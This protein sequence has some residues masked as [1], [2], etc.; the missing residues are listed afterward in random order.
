MRCSKE[1]PCSNCI[2]RDIVED[3]RREVVVLTKHQKNQP[4]SNR[5]SITPA[6][7][8]DSPSIPSSAVEQSGSTPSANTSSA[9]EHAARL[10]V[11][12]ASD[13]TVSPAASR[14]EL[15]MEAANALESLA[16]GSHRASKVLQT[17]RPFAAPVDVPG[18]YMIS[19]W[20]EDVMLQFHRESIA[21]THNICHMPAFI[22]QCRA[23]RN[24]KSLPDQMWLALYHAIIS[25]S[26]QLCPDS[27]SHTCMGWLLE[28]LPVHRRSV[29]PSRLIYGLCLDAR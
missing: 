14:G 12:N 20:Q 25:V 8:N 23:Y 10:K 17:D 11:L 19:A 3:C 13:A 5:T 9:P 18:D 24:T 28:D 4:S 15:A 21:W 6:A 26:R 29:A 22:R 16:W 27:R 1:L 2:R 7:G